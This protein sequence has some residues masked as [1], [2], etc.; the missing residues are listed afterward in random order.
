[1]PEQTRSVR[2]GNLSE[3]EDAE[4]FSTNWQG[5]RGNPNVYWREFEHGDEPDAR[6]YQPQHP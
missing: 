3:H 6:P 4:G 2:V 1:M 5:G